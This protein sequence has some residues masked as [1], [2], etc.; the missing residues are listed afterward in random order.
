MAMQ[1]DSKTTCDA[2]TPMQDLAD[3][4]NNIT[5]IDKDAEIRKLKDL[6]KSIQTKLNISE[7]EI[8][9]LRAQVNLSCE[10][11]LDILRDGQEYGHTE[12]YTESKKT[13][14]AKHYSWKDKL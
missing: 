3:T 4:F 5:P 6:C 14:L 2:L 1:E 9:K 10:K 13:E 7:R 11:M 8:A 12:D